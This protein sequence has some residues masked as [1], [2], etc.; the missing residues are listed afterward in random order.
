MSTSRLHDVR[1]C[2]FDAYG[3]LFDF[4]SA[5]NAAPKSAEDKRRR[6]TGLWRDKQLQYTWLRTLQNRYADFWQVTGEALDFALETPRPRGPGAQAAAHGPLP[7]ARSVPGG[8]R[9]SEGGP[10]AA[11]C[12]RRSS[13]T[14]R[15]RCSGGSSS[16][17]ALRTAST[18][19]SPSTPS[20]FQ[21]P[22]AGLPIR[23]RNARPAGGAIAFQSSN[24]WD[25]YAASDFGMRVVWC[26]R[27][28]QAASAC[29]ARRTPRCGRWRSC[30]GC[31]QLRKGQPLLR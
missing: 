2:V 14:A 18:R 13:P 21:D 31:W 7:R 15:R 10:R 26:N 6:L 11:A 23:A 12:A 30:R 22:S 19:F 8:P 5:A 4:A 3:T 20:G 27:H 24:G 17:P 1:A 29:R 16:G 25:A 28:G 9:R